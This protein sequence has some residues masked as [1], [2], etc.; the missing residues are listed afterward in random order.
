[1]KED[2]DPDL[3]GM[4]WNEAWQIINQR[5]DVRW[6]REVCRCA[7]NSMAVRLAAERRLHQVG[8]LSRIAKSPSINR[9]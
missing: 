8:R 3:S 2:Q 7:D 9:L 5:E 4:K 1:M 6:L